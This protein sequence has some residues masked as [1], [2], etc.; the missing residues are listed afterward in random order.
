VV[1]C[2]TLGTKRVAPGHQYRALETGY[3]FCV[4]SGSRSRP[5]YMHSGHAHMH[6]RIRFPL[7]LLFF[8]FVKS[9]SC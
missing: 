5:M 6:M 2:C 9:V 8:H 1:S 7:S 3:L 4:Q